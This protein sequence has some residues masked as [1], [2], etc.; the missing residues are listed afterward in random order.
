MQT[1]VRRPYE[2]KMI[3]RRGALVFGLGLGALLAIVALGVA[4]AMPALS[5]RLDNMIYRARSYYRKMMPHPEYLPTPAP[6]VPVIAAAATVT[7]VKAEQVQ[8][9][10]TATPLPPTAVPTLAVSATTPAPLASPS[11]TA[12]P[13]TPIPTVAL[14][15]VSPKIQL[16]GFTHQWQTWNNCGPATITMNMSYYGRP[17]TQV[18]A[19]KFL[20]PNRDDKNVSPEELAAFARTTGLEAIVRRGGSMDQLK[21]LLSNNLPVLV[22]TWLVHDGDSLGHYRLFIGYDDAT[23]QFSAFDSLNGPDVKVGYEAFDADWRVF[24]RTYIVVYPPEQAEKVAAIIGPDMDDKA[25][26]ERILNQAEAEVKA[27]PDDPIAYFNQGDALTFLGRFQEAVVAF[28]RAR[29]LGLHWRRL[30]YQ[31]TPFEAYYAAGRYQDVLDLTQATIKGAG[32]LE[33][34]YYYRG[35]A[36][37]A[38]GQPG[39]EQEFQAAVEY[40]PNFTPAAEAL[41][42]VAGG[43]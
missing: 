43:G 34:A 7:P 13:P 25:M 23:G 18:E 2:K 27:K 3:T 15:S 14:A 9:N 39:A 5:P 37:Q 38:T 4:L 8:L 17:E 6:T 29:Q 30:W 16:S 28:D 19:A 33:E 31:F 1:R 40:N 22:E 10:P 20:K 42:G 24:N 26:Y 35:L 11:P 36:L 21:L 12:V 32:G 41:S